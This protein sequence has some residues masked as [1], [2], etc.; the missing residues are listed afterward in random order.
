[1][2]GGKWCLQ[3]WNTTI[4]VGRWM[5]SKNITIRLAAQK[6]N[7][8]SWKLYDM[9][10]GTWHETI[11][12]I[13]VH[14]F[15][16]WIFLS[17]SLFQKYLSAQL[18]NTENIYLKEVLHIP[19]KPRDFSHIGRLFTSLSQKGTLDNITDH[20]VSLGYSANNKTDRRQRC[21]WRGDNSYSR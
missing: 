6:L 5:G 7:N 20:S 18:Y 10:H 21:A 3:N 14:M 19:L 8:C 1:M 16:F 2:H 9:A 15:G 13:K 12:I 11:M 4:E 17:L